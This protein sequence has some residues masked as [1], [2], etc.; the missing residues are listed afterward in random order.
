MKKIISIFFIS[1]CFS[2]ILSCSTTQN[3]EVRLTVLTSMERIRHN[4]APFGEP[5]A[6]IKAAKN[7]V[8]SFQVA[9]SAL[10][11]NIRVVKAEMSDLS[12][13]AGTIGKENIALFRE[14]NTRVR[15]SSGRA[16]LPPGLY[17]DP[18]VPFINPQTGAPIEPFSQH[19]ERWG[20]PMISSGFDMY[21]IPFDVWKGENQ[22]IW[23]DVSIPK[24]AAAGDYEGTFTITLD[25]ITRPWGPKIDSIFT[26]V[27]SIPISVTVWDFTLP[28][29]P[30]HRNHFGGV[31]NVARIFGVETNSEKF[32]EI[33]L[34]YCSMMADNRINPPLPQSLL[35]EVNDDGSLKITPQ[36]HEALKKFMEDLHVTDFEIPRAPIKDMT[37]TNRDKAV[38]YYRDYYKYVNENRWDKR[39]YVYM[40]DEPNLQENYENVLE[41]GALV[42]E[43]A[44]QLRCLVVEQPYKQ[45][46]SWPDID[47]A[48]DIW[49]PLFAFIDRNSIDEKLAHGDEVWSYTALSLRAPGYHP[50][51]D[52][53]KD[54]DSPYWHIDAPLTSYRTPT[55]MNWQ[56][57]I[58]GLLYWS[59]VTR[60]QDAWHLPAFAESGTHF[61]GGGYLIYPGLPCGIDGPVA[62]IRLKNLRDSMEDY[63]YFVL[64][65]EL[66]GREAVTKIV[67]AVA[68]EW[69]ATAEDPKVILSA[70]EMLAGEIL[71]LKK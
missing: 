53:V 42:H 67:N 30:T 5:Q 52:E 27:V 33:E 61:N 47:P 22:P 45:D 28:D 19:R 66:A 68:P 58:N 51:Y 4:Q 44:P 18:L 16:Q 62:S 25:N 20:E 3:P 15:R 37:T 7:E 63:E 64:F 1:I 60:V 56:Y 35:P 59:T 70:R 48:V 24:N 2:T 21:A 54:H 23:V 43:A 40:L 26:K 11:K 55:W 14:E 10:Q 57:R 12:G 6:V 38:R 50:H 69:W 65:E 31:R 17:P 46:P 71:K 9:V 8:E 36:R 29:G 39:A 32:Q 41:L 34:R 49:C 13:K